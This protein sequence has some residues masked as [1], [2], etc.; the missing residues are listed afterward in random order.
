M[1][2]ITIRDLLWLTLTIALG[3]G[4]LLEHSRQEARFN[5]ADDEIR[6]LRQVHLTDPTHPLY[7]G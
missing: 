4:W 3:L 2:R 1:L 7:P 6:R 5:E